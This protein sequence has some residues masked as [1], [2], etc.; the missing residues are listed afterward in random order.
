MSAPIP[1]AFVDAYMSL[2]DQQRMKFDLTY[3]AE[4]K[5]PEI[6]LICAIFGVYFFYMG[7]I[8]KGVALLLSFLVAFGII[9]W[10]LTMVNAKKEINKHNELVAQKALAMVR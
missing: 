10:I 3:Q 2:N 6:G 1:A 5:S 4:A 9:W 8:G 7:Q